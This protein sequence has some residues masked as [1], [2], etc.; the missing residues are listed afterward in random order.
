MACPSMTLGLSWLAGLTLLDTRNSQGRSRGI[1][2]TPSDASFG[3]SR[4]RANLA[5]IRQTRPRILFWLSDKT[6][7]NIL[8]FPLFAWQRSGVGLQARPRAHNLWMSMSL[9]LS[10]PHYPQ[11]RCLSWQASRYSICIRT[12]R[13]RSLGSKSSTHDTFKD[14]FWPCLA[15]FSEFT[16]CTPCRQG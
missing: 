1:Y 5:R 6:P 11:W 8:S 12:F 7:E 10:H 3:Q 13:G 15:P 4:C 2:A 16:S 9:V 14:R